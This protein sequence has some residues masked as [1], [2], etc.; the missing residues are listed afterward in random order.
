MKNKVSGPIL[1]KN[2]NI[3]IRISPIFD[4]CEVT[5]IVIPTVPKAEK[6]SNSNG[7]KGK[8]S[9]MVN[10]KANINTVAKLTVQITRERIIISLDMD[11]LNSTGSSC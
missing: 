1:P 6:T 10:A 7:S 8:R 9:V 3:Q 4:S 2:I 11:L 5:P